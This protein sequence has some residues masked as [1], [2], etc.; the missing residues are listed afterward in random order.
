MCEINFEIEDIQTGLFG[1]IVLLAVDWKAYS[2]IDKLAVWIWLWEEYEFLI[3][4]KN[5][6][7]VE[8][9]LKSLVESNDYS[10]EIRI[11]V[12]EAVRYLVQEGFQLED[13]PRCLL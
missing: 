12:V 4:Y 11:L 6:Y 3:M 9:D 10:E 1:Q 13:W 7:E 2:E 8:V 5:W